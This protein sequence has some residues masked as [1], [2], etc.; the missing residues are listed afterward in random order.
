[1][2]GRKSTVANGSLNHQCIWKC[3]RSSINPFYILP[4]FCSLLSFCSSFDVEYVVNSY[5][6]HCFH[7]RVHCVFVCLQ[8]KLLLYYD[9][10]KWHRKRKK[11]LLEFDSSVLVVTIETVLCHCRKKM[12]RAKKPFVLKTRVNISKNAFKSIVELNIILLEFI[13]SHSQFIRII[14]F[15]GGMLE[16]A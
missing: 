12:K 6:W 4:L 13:F 9:K 2:Y 16:R 10:R 11:N 7:T 8:R 5:F 15:G 3:S 1:M 14:P